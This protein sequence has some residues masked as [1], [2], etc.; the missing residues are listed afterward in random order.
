MAIPVLKT[1]DHIQTK[2]RS[3]DHSVSD[4]S[5]SAIRGEKN[6]LRQKQKAFIDTASHELRTPLTLI[7]GYSEL[8]ISQATYEP[9]DIETQKEMLGIILENATKLELTIDAL[10]DV[11]RFQ[12]HQSLELNK[13]LCCVEDLIVDALRSL[14]EN[15]PSR[16]SVNLSNESTRIQVDLEK[17]QKVLIE[18]VTNAIK[19]STDRLITVSGRTD[20]NRYCLSVQD[21][22]PGMPAEQIDSI[23]KPFYRVDSSTTT[24]EG[25]GFGLSWAKGIVDSH[26]GQL[27]VKSEVGR[28]TQ[29]LMILPLWN[30]RADMAKMDM[31]S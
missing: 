31:R 23:F 13:S 11:K 12:S 22:G 3:Q 16:I 24:Q 28:G 30:E 15:N 1:M 17:I 26:G 8:L 19:F 14:H 6:T 7:V 2:R 20:G 25:L 10:L 27:L 5:A 18:L 9:L 29:V 21:N 4:V